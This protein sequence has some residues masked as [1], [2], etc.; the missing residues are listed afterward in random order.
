MDTVS[1]NNLHRKLI[2]KEHRFMTKSFKVMCLNVYF[3]FYL[4][5]TL[6]YFPM[7]WTGSPFSRTCVRYDDKTKKNYCMCMF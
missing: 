4:K 3:F 1:E 5:I 6:E 2:Y 7:E